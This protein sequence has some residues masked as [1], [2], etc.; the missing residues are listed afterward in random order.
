MNQMDLEILRFVSKRLHHLDHKV[1][2]F[3]HQT[4]PNILSI[5]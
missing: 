5:D 2:S 3:H 4:E 1:S